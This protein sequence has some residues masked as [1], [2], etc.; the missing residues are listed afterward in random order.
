MEQEIS[1]PV[2]QERQERPVRT[3][4]YSYVGTIE[5]LRIRTDAKGRPWISFRLQ[6][7][8]GRL[9]DCVAFG[10][11]ASAFLSRL[12]LGASMAI[13]GF[14]KNR[15]FLRRDGTLGKSNDFYLIGSENKTD[16]DG[17]APDDAR[18]PF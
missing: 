7:S 18:L 3:K 11:Q 16:P 14:F 6:A 2:R 4:R 17:S 5:R 10:A 8:N 9:M 13:T 15:S 12:T 1:S